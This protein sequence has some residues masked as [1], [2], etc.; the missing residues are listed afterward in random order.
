MKTLKAY[1]VLA[2]STAVFAVATPASAGGVTSPGAV[3]DTIDWTSQ[4]GPE[5][6]LVSPPVNV[7]TGLGN[8]VSVS[9][10]GGSLTRIDQSSGWGGNFA[11]GAELLWT[12]P[13]G[14]PDITL[15]FATPVSAVGAQIQ[16]DFG[17]PFTAEITVNG[18]QSFTEN[19][20]SNANADNSAIY[21][22]W[23]GGPISSVEFTLTSAPY[24]TAN[25][26]AIGPVLISTPGPVPG[27]G[28][29]GLAALALA[30][31]FARTRRI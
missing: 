23:Q 2:A 27:A 29:A 11:P 9:S 10:A 7:A 31:L 24:G 4:L 28:V 26:F 16:S 25:D 3:I 5:F 17:G 6:T 20:V 22:G 8:I 12:T 15:T 30:G 18:T 13:T 19:G 1:L 21:I 14:G